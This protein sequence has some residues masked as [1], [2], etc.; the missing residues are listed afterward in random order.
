MIV[1]I[2]TCDEGDCK[3]KATHI[4]QDYDYVGCYCEQHSKEVESRLFGNE[5]IEKEGD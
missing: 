2:N 1:E 4:V 5:D 3:E